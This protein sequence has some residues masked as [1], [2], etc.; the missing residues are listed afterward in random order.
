MY[1]IDEQ[2]QR[3]DAGEV[4]AMDVLRGIQVYS[5]PLSPTHFMCLLAFAI[6]VMH[7]IQ[8]QMRTRL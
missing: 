6:R 1:A 5:L 8:P 2:L 3:L 7:V 4:G